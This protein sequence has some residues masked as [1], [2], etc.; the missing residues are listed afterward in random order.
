[1]NSIMSYGDKTKLLQGSE[2]CNQ[3]CLIFVEIIEI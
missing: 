3:K 1:M 2:T